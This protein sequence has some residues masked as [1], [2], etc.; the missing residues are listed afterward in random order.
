VALPKGTQL[1]WF[2]N[3]GKG[4][5]SAGPSTALARAFDEVVVIDVTGDGRLDVVASSYGTLSV[6]AGLAGGGFSTT[7][8][9]SPCLTAG[10]GVQVGDFNGDGHL[11]VAM[12]STAGVAVCRGDG[13]G[14]FAAGDK[15]TVAGGATLY[16][17]SGGRATLYMATSQGVTAFDDIQ[18][19]ALVNAASVTT[20]QR[21]LFVGA[22][23]FN[24]DAK[25]DLLVATWDGGSDFA[26]RV[27]GREPSGFGLTGTYDWSSGGAVVGDVNKDGALDLVHDTGFEVVVVRG[28]GDGT[29]RAAPKWSLAT[30]GTL[31]RV[32][33]VTGDGRPDIVAVG[34][35]RS[36][37]VF[38][39]QANGSPTAL[40]PALL[41]GSPTALELADFDGDGRVDLLFS[42]RGPDELDLLPGD[43]KGAFGAAQTLNALGGE[44]AIGDID[45]DAKPDLV[46]IA[47]PGLTAR[48][49]KSGT[50]KPVAGI[51]DFIGW[52]RLRDFDGDGRL[53]LV[54]LSDDG[55][56]QA[57]HFLKGHGDGT[58]DTSIDTPQAAGYG[59]DVAD[60]DG[61]HDLDLV[62]A[63][64]GV[65][66]FLFDAGH[67]GAPIVTTGAKLMY[68]RELA[69]ADFDNDGDVDLAY[70]GGYGMVVLKGDRTGRFASAFEFATQYVD[71]LAVG[72][73]DRDGRIDL[74]G[75]AEG[76]WFGRNITGLP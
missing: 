58:F 41:A 46:Q 73:V 2:I 39:A 59:V 50:W 53:D 27:Y 16:A 36:L 9:D 60:L 10:L 11:D 33:D 32:A 8:R 23:D 35:S 66:A 43:G 37:G 28:R 38:V 1:D 22:G 5:F 31:T 24:G 63:A 52:H 55:T 72:D 44:F 18:G 47:S 76:V 49:S 12:G 13:T 19:G 17:S 29:L 70:S 42:R 62:T 75:N 20:T 7:G 74:V 15:Y 56:T 68:L 65:S 34:G 4:H 6:Y 21:I 3:D 54:A 51:T 25:P 26:L 67:F 40:A 14:S 48:L 69:L 61:D 57:L 30:S 64:G 71:S 45:G